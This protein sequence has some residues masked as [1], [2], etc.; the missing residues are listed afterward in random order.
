LDVW[1]EHK[2]CWNINFFFLL[3]HILRIFG[4]ESFKILIYEL[5]FRLEKS[6]TAVNVD[7]Y[8]IQHQTIML[9]PPNLYVFWT[10]LSFNL[11]SFSKNKKKNFEM[12]IISWKV[13]FIL[14]QIHRSFQK[15]K[16]A[17][18]RNQPRLQLQQ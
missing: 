2:S 13:E 15:L 12:N 6:R 14:L 16:L 9:T 8:Y 11:F 18:N 4:I 10:F 3:K 7:L 5:E 17:S 1:I